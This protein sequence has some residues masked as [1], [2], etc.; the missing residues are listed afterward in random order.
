MLQNDEAFFVPEPCLGIN[1]HSQWQLMPGLRWL[2][3]AADDPG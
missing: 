3:G 1:V 2:A